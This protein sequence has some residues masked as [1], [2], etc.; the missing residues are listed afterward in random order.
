MSFQELM[1]RSTLNKY[2]ESS[3]DLNKQ[4]SKDDEIKELDEEDEEEHKIES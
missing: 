2:S 1:K 3:Q 4:F